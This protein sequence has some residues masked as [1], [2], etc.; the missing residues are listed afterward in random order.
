MENSV[1]TRG[2]RLAKLFTQISERQRRDDKASTK[3]LY[4]P[5]GKLTEV[6]RG[7]RGTERMHKKQMCDLEFSTSPAGLTFSGQRVYYQHT[8]VTRY[9]MPTQQ[10]LLMLRRDFKGNK[11]HAPKAFVQGLQH[12]LQNSAKA[13]RPQPV[14]AWQLSAA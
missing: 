9:A 3:Y 1:C 2:A 7:V 13:P 6:E 4:A 10:F 5:P 8:T 14:P 12:V 11:K